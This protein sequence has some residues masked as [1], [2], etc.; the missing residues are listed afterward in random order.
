[1]ADNTS[2]TKIAIKNIDYVIAGCLTDLNDY[3]TN[4]YAQFLYWALEGY[5]ELNLYDYP[6]I[7]V[8]YLTVNENGTVDLPD[9]YVY[10]TSIG[11]CVGG[12]VITLGRMDS[13]CLPRGVDDCGQPLSVSDMSIGDGE[14]LFDDFGNVIF[15]NVTQGWF[16]T[17]HFRGGQYVGE[18]FGVGGGFASNYYRID[19]ENRQIALSSKMPDSEIIL[20]YKSTGVNMDGSATIP[21][22]AVQVLK[23][24]VHWCRKEHSN[25]APESAKERAYEIYQDYITKFRA[26]ELSFTMD[27]FMDAAYSGFTMAPKR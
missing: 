26:L 8:A 5:I 25:T 20:E 2:N 14:D 27:E 18:Q 23:R 13:L 6:S 9:D 16:Y 17:P 10:Y 22:E 11:I 24:Y 3:S 19:I 4:R 15:P 21:V 7:K 12:R 1:M